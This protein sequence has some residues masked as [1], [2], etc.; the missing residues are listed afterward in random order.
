MGTLQLLP[1]TLLQ[2]G[3]DIPVEVNGHHDKHWQEV[4]HE[5]EQHQCYWHIDLLLHSY[6]FH[7]Y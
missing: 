5:G 4:H 1:A 7:Q 6:P 2:E 3:G